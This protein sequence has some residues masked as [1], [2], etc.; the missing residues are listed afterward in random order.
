MGGIE[1]EDPTLSSQESEMSIMSQDTY[2]WTD[3]DLSL[4]FCKLKKS[5]IY[6]TLST[7]R[8]KP[9]CLVNNLWMSFLELKSS[10][11]DQKGSW[12][13]LLTC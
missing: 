10:F 12:L 9:I 11:M 7:T 1:D 6:Q 8:D 4:T 5:L 2:W 13:W 3:A